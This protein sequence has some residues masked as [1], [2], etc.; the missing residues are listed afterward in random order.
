MN[1]IEIFNLYI[2]LAMV[3]AFRMKRNGEEFPKDSLE[4][5]HSFIAAKCVNVPTEFRK[6]EALELWGRYVQEE[7]TL[8]HFVSSANSYFLEVSTDFCRRMNELC[9][10]FGIVLSDREL[11][12]ECL[13]YHYLAFL[14]IVIPQIKYS[15]NLVFNNFWLQGPPKGDSTSF[16][17][18]AL[19]PRRLRVILWRLGTPYGNG[20]EGKYYKNQVRRHNLK[21]TNQVLMNTIFQGFKKGLLP[22][23]PH[24]IQK[25]LDNHRV[26]LT[27]DSTIP[28]EMDSKIE[29]YCRQIFKNFKFGKTRRID[30]ALEF[31]NPDTMN[32][33]THSTSVYG[34]GDGGNVGFVRDQYV[35]SLKFKDPAS[36][37]WVNM[38][39]HRSLGDGELIGFVTEEGKAVH[40]PVPVY[41]RDPVFL[42]DILDCF[43]D[44]I[45]QFRPNETGYSKEQRLPAGSYLEAV[46][47]VIVEPMKARLITK[48][49]LGL[50]VRMHKLQKAMRSFFREQFEDIFALTGEP[51]RR[52]HLWKII[53]RGFGSGEG[54]VSADFS[55]AT[56]NLK[57]AV[58]Q[59]ILKYGLADKIFPEDPRLLTNLQQTL[60]GLKILQTRSVLPKYGNLLDGFN[61]HLEDFVQTNGQL[62]GHVISF[63]I[64]CIANLCSYWDSWERYLGTTLTLA[65][66]RKRHPCL[67][68]GDDL[69]FKGNQ[70]HYKIWWST[71]E[72]YGLNPSPGK[73]YFSDRFLQLNSELWRIDT[74]LDIESEHSCRLT[75]LVLVPYVNFG[76]ITNR[77]KQDCSIDTTVVKH[78]GDISLDSLEERLASMPAIRH[79][80]L[81][82]LPEDVRDR[83][84]PLFEAHSIGIYQHF[85]L[86]SERMNFGSESFEERFTR[87]FSSGLPESVRHREALGDLSAK[88]ERG[89]LSLERSK[90]E[91]IKRID[92]KNPF[93]SFA[94]SLYPVRE[95]EV[96]V[97][98]LET[99]NALRR[100]LLDEDV[101]S[102]DELEADSCPRS[103]RLLNTTQRSTIPNLSKSHIDR[104]GRCV[105]PWE[106]V[107]SEILH[108]EVIFGMC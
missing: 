1:D 69:L 23:E 91:E 43:K 95:K 18:G 53:G 73:N 98:V 83:T 16:L 105:I 50:H 5:V 36:K 14:G 33:S 88:L 55:A 41:Q 99:P 56:D 68:N 66:L 44:E 79:K 58:T 24:L 28:Q 89:H 22:L 51:L 74:R 82:N 76:L 59:A 104:K 4:K 102:N 107:N 62:M 75:N 86:H 93:A 100:P 49:G 3:K 40:F 7:T 39:I 71:V 20:S 12:V 103:E 57:G 92:L 46:P 10:L 6:I 77:K 2:D 26:A 21:L 29:R 72:E 37:E 65:Q 17:G 85:K 84:I 108:I 48:P 42:K 9:S 30:D 47:A 32:Q 96:L 13:K 15:T 70:D 67:I 90:F 60:Q 101:D 38:N 61:Y 27:K 34:Y 80:L 97:S 11:E 19:F 54:M 64:L 94:D 8:E 81:D 63:L 45:F 106:A 31:I 52:D 78:S 87:C 25:S 35:S